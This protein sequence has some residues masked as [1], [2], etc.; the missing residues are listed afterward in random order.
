MTLG[1]VIWAGLTLVGAGAA[2]TRRNLVHAA[3][4]LV[5]T[6]VGI[7]G[8]YLQLAAPFVGLTQV[9]VYVG[10]VAILV[11]FAI[12]LTQG[13]GQDAGPR[14]SEPLIAS[15]AVAGL[16][17]GVL[18]AVL[19]GGFGGRPSAPVAEPSVR[20]IGE[21][22]MTDGVLPLEVMALLLTAA[23]IGAVVVALPERRGERRTPPGAS[24]NR[25]G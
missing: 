15:L 3:L 12:L 2:L 4:W 19:I 22:L 23:L 21:R 8:L 5:V 10:A 24:E 18:A 1:F 7:A 20:E 25:E 11:V 14:V 6:F 9:L 16:V 17:F 13:G